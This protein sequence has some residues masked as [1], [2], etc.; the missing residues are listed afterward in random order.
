[1][2]C[3]TIAVCVLLTL[4]PFIASTG[5]SQSFW[6]NSNGGSW[7]NSGNW[8]GGT[9]GPGD[10]AY[11]R[12]DM[13]G[14]VISI[15][16]A[17][18]NPQTILF[19]DPS[20]S[21]SFQI[22]VTLDLKYSGTSIAPQNIEIGSWV[23]STRS[24]SVIIE[25]TGGF[26]GR[27]GSLF[28][29]HIDVNAGS[30]LR[31]E[32]GSSTHAASVE[33]IGSGNL[34]I[35][36][37]ELVTQSLTRGTG[38][39]TISSGR[40]EIVGGTFDPNQSVFNLV[41]A[42]GVNTSELELAQGASWNQQDLSIRE[43]GLLNVV[44]ASSES[45]L[46]IDNIRMEGD[47]PDNPTVINISNGGRIAVAQDLEIGTGSNVHRGELNVDGAFGARQST[48]TVAGTGR[49]ANSSSGEGSLNVI[50]GGRAEFQ[51]SLIVGS[52]F[53]G[54]GTMLIDG[55]GSRV[56]AVNLD[57]GGGQ[58]RSTGHAFVQDG[59][60]LITSESQIGSIA[61]GSGH[62]GSTGS[63]I[64]TGAGSRWTNA[65]GIYVGGNNMAAA[66]TGSVTVAN[67]GLIESNALT[68]YANGSVDLLG[69][70]LDV[71]TL[72]FADPGSSSNFNFSAGRLIVDLV[73]GDLVQD[74]G[75][76]A[77][78]DSPGL[79]DI[80]GNYFLN[81][82]EI[83]FELEGYLRAM[84][85]DAVNVTG[86]ALLNGTFD[87]NLTGGF[88]PVTGDQ[89]D[90]FDGQIVAG[91]VYSFDFTDAQLASGLRWDTSLFASSGVISVSAVPE[92][93]SLVI[94]GALGISAFSRRRR[95]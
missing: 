51:D 24:A 46:S 8:S 48:L 53:R 9:P 55:S 1:M 68:V 76:L 50:N 23:N 27:W 80:Q 83:E 36:G 31:L 22:D 35:A 20:N 75:V 33:T 4:S 94:I 34:R 40:V 92:P 43:G 57:V 29:T 78:G 64:V 79:T 63:V 77:P 30:S 38:P 69:G 65:N 81:S 54:V 62:P 95:S 71:N 21:S 85:F 87:V 37:G 11:F 2:N 19:N 88:N 14:D 47:I 12:T 56:E 89:F 90:I 66:G 42:G 74:G 39:F 25:G 73:S 82:G 44:G 49:L 13:D 72:D 32:N 15:S 52:A 58:V 86:D 7:E 45:L 60:T 16:S 59:A 26:V 91:S 70:T 93:G 18:A 61:P 6:N 3:Q 67:S 84:D 17:V 10:T 28:Q 41:G 5:Y